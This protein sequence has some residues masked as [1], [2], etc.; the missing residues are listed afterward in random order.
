MRLRLTTLAAL[1]GLALACS[2][3]STGP[4]GP[5]D[6]NLVPEYV[7]SLASSMDAAGIGGARLPPELALT[8]EQKAAIAALHEA[9]KA[10]TAADVATLKALEAEARAARHAGKSREEIHAILERGAPI[11]ARL[12]QAFAALQAAIWQ[13][14]TPEQRAWIDAHRPKPCGPDGPPPLTE[15]QLQQIRALQAAFVEAVKPDLALIRQV[16]QQ[17]HQA[18]QAG[19]TREEIAAILHQADAARAR[20]HEAELR[21]HQAIDAILTPEQ[22]AGRCQPV[23][24]HPPR[25]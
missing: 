19:A 25:P 6:L 18:A 9:F 22:R 15:A 2:G 21:L 11:L 24:H 1:A 23:G 10:A 3:E 14:Y 12:A 20:V 4:G 8:A 13:V 7:E 5:D 16:V 17:A